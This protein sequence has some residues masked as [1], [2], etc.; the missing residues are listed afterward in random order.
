MDNDNVIP[1]PKTA[2]EIKEHVEGCLEAFDADPS[3][4]S[5]QD[6]YEACL[7]DLLNFI[8]GVED[9]GTG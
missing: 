4:N 9:D 3:D 6:G 8:N 1:F 2:A 5:F 7:D